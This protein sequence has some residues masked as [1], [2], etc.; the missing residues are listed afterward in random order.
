MSIRLK[1]ILVYV[2]MII[3][4]ATV[5]VF[6]TMGIIGHYFARAS[7]A[8]FKDKKVDEVIMEMVDLLAELK[9]AEKLGGAALLDME[10]INGL[11]SKV[12]TFNGKLY[13]LYEDQW[14][15]V[16]EAHYDKEYFDHLKEESISFSET[17]DHKQR[18]IDE[19]EHH[20]F[21]FSQDFY[22]NGKKVSYYIVIDFSALHLVQGNM[23]RALAA[24]MLIILLIVILPLTFILSKDIIKP[25]KVLETGANRIREGDLNFNL[26]ARSNDEIGRVVNAF[27]KMRMELKKSIERQLQYEENRKELIS[28]ISHDL[29][30]PITSIKGYVQGIMDGVADDGEKLDKYL[31]VISSKSQD[32]DRLI[33]D[34]FMFSKLDLD[35]LT[36][37]MGKTDIKKY[38]DGCVSELSLEYTQQ[39]VNIQFE[40]EAGIDVSIYMDQQMIKRVIMNIVQNAVKYMNKAEKQLTIR[41]SDADKAINFCITDNG[42]GIAPEKLPHIFDKFY[43]VDAARNTQQGGS[44][45]GL[46]IA[47]QIIEKHGGSIYAESTL[48]I[49][50]T[51]CFTLNKIEVEKVN[52]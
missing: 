4:S 41:V 17:S 10:F 40:Y 48:D 8:V 1:L 20:D 46:A 33:D 14:I 6:S 13:V 44:G 43:R 5:L 9:A 35:R 51:I 27:D 11:D 49:G 3:I 23:G 24:L 31:Q 36:F 50:T 29:K 26:R 47:K 25:L 34:L 38:M 2:V 42:K 19:K 15:N 21:S 16:P 12:S 22:A 30:T 39:G 52:E 32:M 45:L 7:E 18:I 37:N 28:S